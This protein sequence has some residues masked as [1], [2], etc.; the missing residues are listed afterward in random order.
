MTHKRMNKYSYIFF[1]TDYFP[2]NKCSRVEFNLNS[3]FSL[4]S[5]LLFWLIIGDFISV[6]LGALLFHWNSIRS[7]NTRKVKISKINH[8]DKIIQ[9]D[10]QGNY[11][12]RNYVFLIC[13]FFCHVFF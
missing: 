12:Y 7:D 1:F 6:S 4:L 2:R 5:F 8:G 11:N 13:A 3:D 10:F 9:V